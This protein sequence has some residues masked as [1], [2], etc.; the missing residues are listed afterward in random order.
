MI[1]IINNLLVVGLFFSIFVKFIDLILE[2]N[3]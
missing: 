1:D 2:V 3:F